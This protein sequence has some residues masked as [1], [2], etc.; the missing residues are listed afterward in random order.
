MTKAEE[1]VAKEAEFTEMLANR[2][3]EAINQLTT[4][5]AEA[6]NRIRQAASEAEALVQKRA[7][8]AE[9]RAEDA[10]SRAGEYAEQ[11]P[12]AAMGLAV[13]AGFIIGALVSRRK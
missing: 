10:L 8:Q 11:N 3:H 4:S 6:E 9:R 7:R 1:S 5:T 2:A 12:L 13:A